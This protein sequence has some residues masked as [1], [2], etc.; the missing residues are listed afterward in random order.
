MPT[1]LPVRNRV[2]PS[3]VSHPQL[4]PCRMIRERRCSQTTRASPRP[5]TGATSPWQVA[6][7]VDVLYQTRIQRERFQDRPEQYEQ[8]RMR[9][10][11]FRESTGLT[12]SCPHALSR[13][14]PSVKAASQTE[15][16]CGALLL[17]QARGK[18]IVD[19]AVMDVMR[20]DAI[21][22]HPLPRLDEIVT[23]VDDDPR[24]AYFRQAKNGLYIRM[25]LLKVLLKA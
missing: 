7:S 16:A 14:L 5:S 20:P 10:A 24:C 3:A 4:L 2:L 22:M 18:F 19:Q 23:E 9:S 6:A 21:V 12:P 1:V 8:V 11:A 25:A 15:R 13:Y 17:W